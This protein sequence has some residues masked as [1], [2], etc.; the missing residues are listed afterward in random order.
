MSRL[1]NYVKETRSELKHVSWPT[2]YQTIIYTVLV[3]GI[4]LFIA[5]FLGIFDFVFSNILERFFVV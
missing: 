2:K 1:I 5:V 4:S 3:V